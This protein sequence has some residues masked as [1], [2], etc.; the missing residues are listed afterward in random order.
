MLCLQK[1]LSYRIVKGEILIEDWDGISPVIKTCLEDDWSGELRKITCK[2][3]ETL[4]DKYGEYLDEKHLVDFYPLL[5]ARLEDSKNI[6]R[7]EICRSLCSFFRVIK[8][9]LTYFA[10][11]KNILKS[12]FTHLDDSDEQ[13]Q[14]SVS[15]VL[16]I[17]L[18]F[19]KAEFLEVATEALARHR[20]PRNV[21]EL[22][23]LTERIE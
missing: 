4:L 10:N 12:L 3:C 14:R 17:A 19:S 8:A 20:H 11:Y 2:V 21:K 6:N 9:K 13:V 7:I 5:L 15:E 18:E 22:I 23:N 16:E 1:A